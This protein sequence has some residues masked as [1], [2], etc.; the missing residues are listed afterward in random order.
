VKFNA[1]ILGRNWLHIQ[2]GSGDEGK[3]NHDIT[4]TTDG[5]AAVGDVVTARGLVILN[6]DYGAGYKYP[7]MIEQ[8]SISR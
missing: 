1:Q 4:V 2:D 3:G 8:A 7:I 5:T 6:K